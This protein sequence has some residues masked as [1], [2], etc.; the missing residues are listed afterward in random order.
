MPMGKPKAI[1]GTL[2][3]IKDFLEIV[4]EM[5]NDHRRENYMSVVVAY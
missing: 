3:F 5:V 2:E 4:C 1:R